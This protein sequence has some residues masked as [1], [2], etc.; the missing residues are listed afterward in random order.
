MVPWRFPIL[1]CVMTPVW[2]WWILCSPDRK[3]RWIRPVGVVE[4]CNDQIAASFQMLTIRVTWRG[5]FCTRVDWA[6][7]ATWFRSDSTFSDRKQ[8]PW[9]FT[10]W[11]IWWSKWWYRLTRDISGSDLLTIDPGLWK[12]TSVGV[13]RK[14]LPSSKGYVWEDDLSH[15]GLQSYTCLPHICSSK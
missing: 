13:P 1:G 6:S 5:M 3:C 10:N 14:A 9:F 15:W 12:D 8:M 2:H 11:F 4:P 7:F